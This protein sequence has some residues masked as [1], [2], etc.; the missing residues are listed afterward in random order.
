V[1][2]VL[3]AREV[4]KLYPDGAALE[5]VSISVASGECIALVGESGSGKT[6]LLRMFNRMVEPSRG[7][8]LREGSDVRAVDPVQLR[9]NTGY[10]QQEGGL[11]PHWTV[12]RN[13]AMVPTLKG[14]PNALELGREALDQV[15][16]PALSF[17]HR[18]PSELSGGQRQRLAIARAIAARPTVLLLD[19]PFGA[20]DAITRMEVREAFDHLRRELRLSSVIVTHDLSEALDLADRVAV[21][22]AGRVEQIAEPTKLLAKPKEGYVLELL[23]RA[24]VRSEANR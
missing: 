2:A 1:T 5:G 19:E 24:G 14:M 23:E 8:I 17:G 20:L 16:L 9:R 10:V 22:R 15:G 4:F 18:R 6:T 21:L 13:A 3:E 11:L 7:V 12:I